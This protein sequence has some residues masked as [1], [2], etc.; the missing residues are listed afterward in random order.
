MLG[1]WLWVA[2]L[3]TASVGDG[4]ELSIEWSAPPACPGRRAVRAAVVSALQRPLAERERPLLALEAEVG[5]LA[6]GF[7]ADLI[8]TSSAGRSERQLKARTCPALV[9]AVAVIVA[10]ALDREAQRVAETA[11]SAQAGNA[12]TATV[13]RTAIRAGPRPVE[14]EPTWNPTVALGFLAGV[15]DLPNPST[16]L[17]LRVGAQRQRFQIDAGALIRFPRTVTL[18]SEPRAG[19]EF[20]VVA[21]TLRGC[22]SPILTRITLDLC[23]GAEVGLL[24]ASGFG[25]AEPAEQMQLWLAGW[26]ELASA[27]RLDEPW[28]LVGRLRGVV[29]IRRPSYALETVPET[30]QIGPFAGDLIIEV[31]L[32]FQ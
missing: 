20:M 24:R 14:P 8:L 18:R 30:F 26:A 5:T 1:S 7:Y 13:T 23:L 21:G 32:N 3:S 11:A 16:G 15:G 31:A 10:F 19:G 9:E 22:Y 27:V 4:T 2:A 17:A 6:R 29:P 28:W 12:S 25:V